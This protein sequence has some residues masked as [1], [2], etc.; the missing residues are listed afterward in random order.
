MMGSSSLR[1]SSCADAEQERAN[2][3]NRNGV[4]RPTMPRRISCPVLCC[5]LCVLCDLGFSGSKT[6]TLKARRAQRELRER[7]EFSFELWILYH[8][9][10]NGSLLRS[11]VFSA[12]SAF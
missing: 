9:V 2:A 11:R 10:K 4:R 1:N 6:K 7:R 3:T 8:Q 12:F 5:L